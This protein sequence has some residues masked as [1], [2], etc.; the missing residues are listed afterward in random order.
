M[1]LP[2]KYA[3]LN[4]EPGPKALT[5]ALKHYGTLEHIG[6]GSNA[7]ILNWAVELKVNGYYTDDDIPWCGLFVGICVSRAGYTTPALLK[8]LGARNWLSWG[9]PVFPGEEKLFDI[10]IFSRTG[11]GHVGFYIGENEK[12][13]LVYGGNQA[14][15]VGFAFI[16]KH[17]LLAA[18]R[19]PWKIGQPENIR[20]IHLSFDGQLS[21][22]EA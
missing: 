16:D 21:S 5:E 4:N 18:R 11:G 14:N 13:F 9:N 20:K 8:M 7:N 3:W 2:N 10:L 1:Q 22:N 12:A 6:K 15:T 17:R 19:Y